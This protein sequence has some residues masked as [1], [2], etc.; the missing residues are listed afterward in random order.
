MYVLLPH[1]NIYEKAKC[2]CQK[3]P[4]GGKLKLSTP[5]LGSITLENKTENQQTSNNVA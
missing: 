4:I 2:C 3:I 1:F 5:L